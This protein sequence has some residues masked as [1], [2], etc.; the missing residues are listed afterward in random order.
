MG[1][2]TVPIAPPEDSQSYLPAQPYFHTVTCNVVVN[3]SDALKERSSV[4][5]VAV[6]TEHLAIHITVQQQACAFAAAQFIMLVSIVE[7]YSCILTAT[8]LTHRGS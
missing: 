8:F 1:E 6:R 4:H 2:Y 3:R 7:P 5:F